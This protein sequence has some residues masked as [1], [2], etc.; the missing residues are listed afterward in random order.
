M[1]DRLYEIAAAVA[2]AKE[3]ID[4]AL[5]HISRIY[6]NTPE[7]GGDWPALG[8]TTANLEKITALLGAAIPQ[9]IV[10]AIKQEAEE[11]DHLADLADGASW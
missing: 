10:D 8:E 2:D 4:D 9:E 1:S 6:A 11:N 5:V 7:G 3:L